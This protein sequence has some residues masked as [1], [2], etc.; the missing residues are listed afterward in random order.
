MTVNE[1]SAGVM[2]STGKSISGAA[3]VLT[4]LVVLALGMMA[5]TT[6][7]KAAPEDAPKDA[8]G[9]ANALHAGLEHLMANGETL[10]PDAAADYI[11]AVVDETY[12]LP[13]LTAQSIGP[14]VFRG[15]DKDE[16]A[17]VVAAYRDFVIA[18][19]VSRFA[20]PLPLSF[21]TKGTSA[22][23]KSAVIV[24]TWL[25]RK[26]GKPINLD[27]VMIGSQEKGYGIADVVYNGVSEAARRRSELSSL[28]REGADI[29]ASTLS[30]KAAQIAP[31]AE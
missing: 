5:G 1:T 8:P 20:K 12:N 24:N 14:S 26:S 30:K 17:L 13:A 11:S 29:V 25:V 23:P 22:G 21:E 7:V 28:A 2:A 9:V 3:L 31:R 10:G 4:A 15:Y 27:Y 6:A 18:N 19:Y 16:R